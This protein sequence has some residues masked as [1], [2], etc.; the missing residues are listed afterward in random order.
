MAGFEARTSLS[1][2]QITRNEGQ[3]LAASDL[4]EAP[5]QRLAAFRRR[6]LT[7]LAAES[8]GPGKLPAGCG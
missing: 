4:N 7:R 3:D 1:P 6:V 5:R 8:K 2:N